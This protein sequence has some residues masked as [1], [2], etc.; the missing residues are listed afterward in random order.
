MRTPN[1]IV[2]NIGQSNNDSPTV[3]QESPLKVKAY[4]KVK[5]KN[6]SES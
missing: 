6:T 5:L 2:Q 4:L 3:Y 1:V